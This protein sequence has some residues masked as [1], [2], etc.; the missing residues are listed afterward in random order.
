LFAIWASIVE[1]MPGLVL[2][3]SF[4]MRPQDNEENLRLCSVKL[5]FNLDA[6][7]IE[8]LIHL[9]KGSDD[10]IAF[11][12]ARSGDFDIDRP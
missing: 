12:F 8:G 5:Q 6:F 4:Q 7:L 9:L 3:I 1:N 2:D 10:Q 11:S